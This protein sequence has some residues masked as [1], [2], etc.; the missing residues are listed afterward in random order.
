M[1]SGA[2]GGV[3]DTAAFLEGDRVGAEGDFAGKVFRATSVGSVYTQFAARIESVSSDGTIA[4]STLGPIAL[5][6]GRLPFTPRDA[7]R[8]LRGGQVIPGT[9]LHGLDWTNPQTG[10]RYLMIH[11]AS[12]K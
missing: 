9:V 1:Y 7:E 10:E 5:T 3:Q 2:Y 4:Q 12:T 6:A 11:G 8:T